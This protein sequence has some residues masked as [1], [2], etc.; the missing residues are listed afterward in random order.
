MKDF[1]NKYISIIFW[2]GF[3]LLWQVLKDYELLPKYILPSPLE[4]IK[5]IFNNYQ[6]IL[7]HSFITIFETFLGLFF[8]VICAC[9]LAYFMNKYKV[10]YKIIHP[11]FI[12]LQTIPTIA[13]A[14]LLVLYLGYNITPKIVLITITTTFPILI[15]LLNGL[16]NYDK[17][18]EFLLK[19]FNAKSKH[20]WIYLKIPTCLPYFFAGLKVAI[21]YAY[22]SAVVSEWLG[23][24]SGLGVYM[25]QAKKLFEYDL[26]FAII[27]IVS[28]LSL[29]SVWIIKIIEKSIFKWRKV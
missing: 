18:Y 21:S 8:G 2:L 19:S 7:H 24:F 14:P 11:F 15:S 29:F 6:E 9:V 16:L 10:V 23:G 3:I 13:I 22:I 26:M 4:I 28:A 1:I 17:D 5:A 20:I 25:I 12:I 27:M